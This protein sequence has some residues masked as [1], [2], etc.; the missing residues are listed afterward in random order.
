M[1]VAELEKECR[2][3]CRLCSSSVNCLCLNSKYLTFLLRV[4]AWLQS[5]VSIFLLLRCLSL[6]QISRDVAE[7]FR[8]SN[9][10][11]GVLFFAMEITL[12]GEMLH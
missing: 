1:R 7:K 6:L 11:R 2:V 12:V 5:Y 10:L 4:H 8:E 3:Y 9:V